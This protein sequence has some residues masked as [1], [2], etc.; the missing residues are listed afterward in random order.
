LWIRFIN[1]I[2][3][4]FC[5]DILLYNSFLLD[6]GWPLR[7]FLFIIFS[8]FSSFF[9]Q[10]KISKMFKTKQKQKTFAMFYS[11]FHLTLAKKKDIFFFYSCTVEPV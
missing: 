5:F 2:F 8:F 6:T 11:V 10:I 4:L 9:F 7:I 1:H 3:F